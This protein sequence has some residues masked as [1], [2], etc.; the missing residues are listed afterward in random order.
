MKPTAL[1]VV[2]TAPANETGCRARARAWHADGP[3]S[4]GSACTRRARRG[5]R[6]EACR[7]SSASAVSWWSSPS[8]PSRSGS[9]IHW[10][11]SSAESFDADAVERALLTALAGDGMA[12]RA[13]LGCVD[14]LAPSFP[15]PV[16]APLGGC[17]GHTRRSAL[18]MNRPPVVVSL[19]IVP[20]LVASESSPVI[21][22]AEHRRVRR[23][24]PVRVTE[25][26]R[27]RL[28]DTVDHAG[29]EREVENPIRLVDVGQASPPA[30]RSRDAGRRAGSPAAC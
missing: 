1:A 19:C 3:I 16:I 29:V 15:H 10:R 6:P 24:R 2:N 18:L 11:V 4:S 23:V 9:T 8:W 14:L 12:H 20:P 7:T 30:A 26:Q 27:A 25:N 22:N 28:H 21:Q 17:P 5:R 13:L